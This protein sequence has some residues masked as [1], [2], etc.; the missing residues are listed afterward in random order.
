MNEG[1]PERLNYLIRVITEEHDD[2]E[3]GGRCKACQEVHHLPQQRH[4][5]RVD[6]ETAHSPTEA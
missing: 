3:G 6:E 4:F 2:D 1:I 5:V